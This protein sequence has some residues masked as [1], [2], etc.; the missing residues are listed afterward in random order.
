MGCCLFSHKELK[1][2]NYQSKL[3]D[4]PETGIKPFSWN[5]YNQ[6]QTQ[7]KTLFMK[8]LGELCLT[9]DKPNDN[10][11][12]GYD[13]RSF[14]GRIFCMAMKVYLGTSSRRMISDLRMCQRLGY[15]N[16]VPHFNSVLNYFNNRSMKKVLK[17]LIE[18]SA[19]PL[20]QLERKFAVDASGIGMHQYD[21]WSSIRTRH[22]EH[23]KYKKIHVIYG[24]LTN[25]AVSCKV[26]QGTANDSPHFAELL[27][28]AA[29][30]WDIEE[31]TADMAYSSR[32]NLKLVLDVG[33]IPFIPFKKNAVAKQRGFEVWNKM[34]NYF[35]NHQEE[36]LRHY[37]KR[38]NAETGFY[39][40]KTKFGE[41]VKAKNDIAQENEILVKILCHNI[42]VLIQEMFLQNV[43]INFLKVKK[44]FVA[45]VES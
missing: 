32:R 33:A 35:K 21:K 17:Y 10:N 20:A 30:N 9:M 19:M 4:Y 8:L 3:S 44:K 40:I 37:H 29:D 5:K 23:R 6:S 16:Q 27:Q 11:F 18:L 14:S 12:S 15:I 24:V 25:V 31:V 39:M 42:C 22:K 41:F 13:I 26:T 1:M 7:E 28:R 45:Q 36:F 43:D 38:S 2:E 34:Y